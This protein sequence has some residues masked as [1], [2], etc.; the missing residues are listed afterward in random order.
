MTNEAIMSEA[1]R[2]HHTQL[3][4]GLRASDRRRSRVLL[5]LSAP[6]AGLLALIVY[7]FVSAA[8]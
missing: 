1:R 2:E 5:A 8:V 3:V 4:A 7:R 6:A